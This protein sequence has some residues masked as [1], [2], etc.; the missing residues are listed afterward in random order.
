M[1]FTTVRPRQTRSESPLA[2]SLRSGRHWGQRVALLACLILS[3][4]KGE[5]TPEDAYRTF[6]AALANRDGDKAFSMLSQ[7]SQEKLT[8]LAQEASAKAQGGVPAD[9]RR[10]IVSG[11]P[12]AKAI[13]EVKVVSRGQ[14]S[15]VISVDDG[16][17][18]KPVKM[19][20]EGLRWKVSLDLG[21]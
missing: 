9:P 15:A 13:K 1:T 18:P 17:G 16:S 8:K 6:A 11:D 3:G 2:A 7:E 10:M 20:R 4:C 21:S 5:T 14:G 19:V 12:A